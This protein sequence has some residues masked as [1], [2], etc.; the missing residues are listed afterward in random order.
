MFLN[1][2]LKD[3]VVSV[4]HKSA[5]NILEAST[6]NVKADTTIGEAVDL[7]TQ[8]VSDFNSINYVYV[9]DDSN[10]LLGV[11]SI[12]ELFR[13]PKTMMVNRIMHGDIVKVKP[14]VTQ[15]RVVY[16]ALKHSLKE[17][18]VVDK[19]NHFLGIIPSD[20]ILSIAYKEAREDLM[21][22]AGLK[23]EEGMSDNI[24]NLPI[25][26]SLKHR[27]PWLLLGLLGGIFSAKII[28]S[29][30]GLLARNLVLASFIPLIVYISG[31]VGAQ[32]SIF[33]IRDLAIS[34]QINLI[35]YFIRQFVVIFL[36]GIVLSIVLA[37]I[38][39][40]LYGSWDVSLTLA[41]SLMLA[42]VSSLVSG[43]IIP[44]VVNKMKMDP[45]NVTGPIGTVVQDITSILIYFAI[46]SLII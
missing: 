24:M 32:V 20:K 30:E 17:M 3:D 41:L 18:P 21:K 45:A 33:L 1:A 13:Q 27:L 10:A 44:T 46:A 4:Q 19:D 35:K 7:L 8:K 23:H 16:L 34:T 14:N 11:F 40:L 9:V 31:A 37:V 39:F 5:L 42:I 36:I 2:A 22:F 28:D 15:E 43:F 29:F 38:S 26:T 6:F 25:L 12:K